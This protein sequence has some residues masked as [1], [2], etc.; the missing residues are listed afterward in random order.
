MRRG[1][2]GGVEWGAGSGGKGGGRGAGAGARDGKG[3][4]ASARAHGPGRRS[5]AAASA[6][7]SRVV[8]R[9]ARRQGARCMQARARARGGGGLGKPSRG[10]CGLLQR[11]L[12]NFAAAAASQSLGFRVG[13][14][15]FR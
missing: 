7:P 9:T 8:R 15:G 1:G 11:R 10:S 12:G 14:L 13:G 3:L 2:E 4:V 6:A 5:A